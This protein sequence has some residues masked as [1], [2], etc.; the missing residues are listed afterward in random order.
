MDIQSLQTY[1]IPVA[2]LLFLIWRYYNTRKIKAQLP[3]YLKQGAVI[4]DVRTASEFN[5]AANPMSQNIPLDIINAKYSEL[6]KNKTI[7][8]CC[9]SGARSGMAAGILRQKGFKNVINAGSWTN[10]LV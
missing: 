9:S 6:D 4:I 5:Q 10:T 2:I 3:K 1:I 8:L 7:I